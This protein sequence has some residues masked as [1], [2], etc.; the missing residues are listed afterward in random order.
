MNI[1]FASN[2]T[3]KKDELSAILD[4]TL[5]LPSA[6]GLSFN[7]EETGTTFIENALI[8]AREL[9]KL[10]PSKEDIVISD[11][12]G[13]CVDSLNGKPGV[14]S[15]YYGM[16]NGQKISSAEQNILLL[17]ELGSNPVR[18]ARFVCAMVL[19]F[20]ENRFFIVQETLEGEIVKERSLS[21]GHGGFGYDP[22]FLLP[23]H[24]RTL[25]ELSADEKNIISHRGK[26]GRHITN[27]ISQTLFMDNFM[28]RDAQW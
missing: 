28:S 14:Q 13:L 19:L 27:I 9:K 25:A 7:P 8:K 5:M 21:R 23:E 11:D 16:K 22:I 20:D 17:E 24:G 6:E 15:A 3:H 10:L 12:S 2:N 26:S 4:T 18:T 1:W